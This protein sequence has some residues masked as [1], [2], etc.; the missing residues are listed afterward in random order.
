MLIPQNIQKEYEKLFLKIGEMRFFNYIFTN[1][2][3]SKKYSE[4]PENIILDQSE[5]FFSLFRSTGN[6]N[7]FI[8]GKILRRVA[9]KLYRHYKKLYSIYPTN[10]KFLQII[11]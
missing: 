9:H 4:H 7:F 6:E 2:L 10:A 8:I 3:S 1:G 5:C 11:K